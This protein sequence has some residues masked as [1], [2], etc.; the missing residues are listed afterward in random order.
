MGFIELFNNTLILLFISLNFF[1]DYSFS[2]LV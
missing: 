2:K 1:F